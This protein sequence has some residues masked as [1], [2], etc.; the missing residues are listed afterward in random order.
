MPKTPDIT[1][2]PA[3]APLYTDAQLASLSCCTRLTRIASIIERVDERCMAVDGPVTPTLQ[4]MTQEEISAVYALA[5]G[6][7]V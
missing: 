7:N 5:I 1:S 6:Y 2:K 3:R 4:E